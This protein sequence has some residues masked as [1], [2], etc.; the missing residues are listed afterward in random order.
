MLVDSDK[1]VG[2]GEGVTNTISIFFFF[3]LLIYSE[4]ISPRNLKIVEQIRY[5]LLLFI[6]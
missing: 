1:K 6:L 3:F 4:Y 5:F 2:M